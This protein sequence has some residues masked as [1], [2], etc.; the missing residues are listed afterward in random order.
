ML[1]LQVSLEEQLTKCAMLHTCLCPR[2]VIGVRM[3]RL[4]CSWLR[5]DPA[6]Q[7]KQLYVYMEV[8]HCAAD[9]VIA[10]TH[11]SPTNGLMNLI[12][13]IST[14]NSMFFQNFRRRLGEFYL[15]PKQ[16]FFICHDLVGLALRFPR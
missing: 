8:G 6:L 5:I 16:Q 15:I 2:Q 12:A 3:A 11:A 14:G 4:A 1:Q 10:V 9:G 13:T 7:R